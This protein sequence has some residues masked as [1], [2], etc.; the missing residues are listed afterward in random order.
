MTYKGPDMKRI[1]HQPKSSAP[2]ASL[3]PIRRSL[4]PVVIKPKLQDRVYK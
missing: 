1:V 2:R 3:E 4:A